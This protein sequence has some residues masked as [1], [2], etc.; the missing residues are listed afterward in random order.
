MQEFIT[1]N[2]YACSNNVLYG[3]G[4][5]YVEDERF[6]ANINKAGGEG[7]EGFVFEAIKKYCGK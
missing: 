6:T 4:K 7:T 3:L 5:M 2:F 1:E